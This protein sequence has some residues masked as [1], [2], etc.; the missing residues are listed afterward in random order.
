MKAFFEGMGHYLIFTKQF[1]VVHV[2]LEKKQRNAYSFKSTKLY[3]LQD[4]PVIVI[5]SNLG[6]KKQKIP[7]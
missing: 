7:H 4:L 6:R 2:T 3:F 1:F 5:H